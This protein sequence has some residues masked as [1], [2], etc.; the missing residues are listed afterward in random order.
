MGE[1]GVFPVTPTTQPAPTVTQDP[2]EQTPQLINGKW[3]Q[4]WSMVNVSAEEASVRQLEAADRAETLA[5]RADT[6]VTNFI[7]MTPAQV[8]AYVEN[9]TANLAQVRSL[10]TKMAVMLLMLAKREYR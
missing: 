1:Y 5:I 4:V 9:N 3:T 7:A 8:A 6:F 2:I 10:M